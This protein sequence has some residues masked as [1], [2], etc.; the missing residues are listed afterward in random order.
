MTDR[1]A[2]LLGGIAL[3]VVVLV[4]WFAV[5]NPQRS[6]VN[7]L[8]QQVASSRQ[9]LGTLMD[10]A[11]AANASRRTVALAEHNLTGMS[12]ALPHSYAEPQ[13][14]NTIQARAKSDHIDF[15]GVAFTAPSTTTTSPGSGASAGSHS[16]GSTQA[17]TGSASG[18]QELGFS[19]TL[20]GNYFD[21]TRLVAQL[22]DM[23]GA[24]A[25][26][27]WAS[28]RFVSFSGLT[29]TASKTA[30]GRVS[31]TLSGSAY[32]LP[33]TLTSVASGAAN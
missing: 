21:M 25:H 11:A 2:P 28:G 6:D 18:A 23:T 30:A 4:G 15:Q 5:V 3:V 22:Q 32:F 16:S 10:Q 14:I 19:L 13:L 17:S 9:E 1:K 7:D 29:L 20:A 27:V 31:A 33:A 26:R 8:K 12:R 24:S